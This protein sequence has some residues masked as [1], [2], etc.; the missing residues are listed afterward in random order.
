MNNN[1]SDRYQKLANTESKIPPDKTLAVMLDCSVGAITGA[2]RRL[3]MEGYGFVQNEDGG[4]MVTIP[5]KESTPEPVGEDGIYRLYHEKVDKLPKN[6]SFFRKGGI[7]TSK[8]VELN[9]LVDQMEIGEIRRLHF[10]TKK[11]AVNAQSAASGH[12]KRGKKDFTIATTIT[13]SDQNGFWLYMEKIK[14][15]PGEWGVQKRHRS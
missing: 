9:Q 2:R 14:K 1:I 13:T 10:S 11:L 3:T 4:W 15:D 6:V 7:D 8:W 5:K 12:C